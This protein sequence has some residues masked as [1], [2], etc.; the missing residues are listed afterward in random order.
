MDSVYE[1]CIVFGTGTLAYEC[2][3]ILK[4]IYKVD[5]VYEYASYKQSRLEEKAIKINLNY[6]RLSN[7]EECD[8]VMQSICQ[9]K[10]STLIVSAS[11]VYIFPN[12][13]TQNEKIKIINYHPALLSMH[14]GRNAEAW[15]I[16]E[17]DEKTGVTWHEVTEQIDQGKV[18]IKQEINLDKEITSIKLMIMQYKLGSALFKK[19]I[20]NILN[21]KLIEESDELKRG[22][23]HMSWDIPNDGKLDLNWEQKKISAFLR[24]MDYGGLDVLGR[25]YIV[26]NDEKYIWDSYEISMTGEKREDRITKSIMRNDITFYLINYRKSGM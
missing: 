24:C 25:P 19:I 14:L 11:N 7:K 2:A 1:K 22:K 23:M 9:A 12:Y 17:Q 21:N 18:L 13:V 8:R 20:G 15:S 26:E 4:S 6:K 10:R 16:F 5:M 3:K